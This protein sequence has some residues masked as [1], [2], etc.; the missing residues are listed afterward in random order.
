MPLG[1]AISKANHHQIPPLCISGV[2]TLL[3][4]SSIRWLGSHKRPWRE[5]FWPHSADGETETQRE[6]ARLQVEGESD[7]VSEHSCQA[8][9]YIVR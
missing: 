4:I 5:G 9:T 1:P 3:E 6:P 8:D 7:P 2:L